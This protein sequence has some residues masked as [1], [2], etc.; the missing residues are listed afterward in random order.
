[1][2]PL[3]HSHV[4]G[5]KVCLHIRIPYALT[6]RINIL[7]SYRQPRNL[8]FNGGLNTAILWFKI[9][10]WMEEHCTP[11]LMR[12][13]SFGISRVMCYNTGIYSYFDVAVSAF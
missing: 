12:A 4:V 9:S 1:V 10:G 8:S 13:L 7:Q 11:S 2:V 5:G 6:V 3:M